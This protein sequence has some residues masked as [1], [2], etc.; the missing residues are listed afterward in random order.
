MF[1]ESGSWDLL[2]EVLRTYPLDLGIIQ[3]DT[4]FT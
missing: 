3:S 4:L 2:I 1:N